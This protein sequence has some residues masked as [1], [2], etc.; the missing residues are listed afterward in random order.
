MT[1]AV[2]N[3]AETR[4][5]LAGPGLHKPINNTLKDEKIA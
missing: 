2:L 3:E 1:E 5:E 4:A